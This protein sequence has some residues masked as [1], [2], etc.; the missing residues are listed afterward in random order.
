[1]TSKPYL[2]LLFVYTKMRNIAGISTAEAKKSYDMFAKCQY[3]S[4]ITM[5]KG[6]TFA[7]GTPISNSMTELYTNMRYL[8]YNLLLNLR[9]GFFDAWAANFGEIKTV[10]ELAPEGTKYQPKTRFSRFYNLSELMS[11]FREC[12][13]IQTAEMLNLPR[14]KAEYINVVLEPSK[15]QQELVKELGK[16]AE[17][18]RRNKIDSHIDN[19]LK[20]THDGR[21]LALE[22]RLICEQYEENKNSKVNACVRNAIQIWKDSALQKGTQLIFCDMATPKKSSSF[23]IYDDIKKKL[24]SAGVPE[25]EISFIHD[26]NTNL[27]KIQLFAKIRKGKVRFL[28]GSTAKMGAGTNVQNRLVAL[29]HIDVPW[30]PSDIDQREGRILRQ[31]NLFDKVMIFRYTTKGTFDSYCWQILENKQRV[32]SQIM[33][34]KS[35]VRSIEDIDEVVLNYAEIKALTTN[36][37]LIQE[38][39]NLELQVAKLKTYKNN[40]IQQKHNMEDEIT[41]YFPKKIAELQKQISAYQKDIQTYQE[42][43]EQQP[44]FSIQIAGTIY[45]DRMIAGSVILQHLYHLIKQNYNF[46]QPIAI[47][48]YL[49]FTL[50]IERN[51]SS[52]NLILQGSIS[53]TIEIGESPIGI[54]VRMNNVLSEFSKHLKFFTQNL[55]YLEE[56]LK[57]A[58][59]EVQKPFPKED[60]LKEKQAR[61]IEVNTQLNINDVK[62]STLAG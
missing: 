62:M 38:K 32:I 7:T 51:C 26:A 4:K 37:P 1:M 29:H 35:S 56:Q 30:R 48:K 43:I 28:L 39:M 14:P 46:S 19:M 55:K 20:I 18:I 8:Q 24:I 10:I 53:H 40:F 6:I 31:G 23:N 58:K 54:I 3:I 27:K 50:Q 57:N 34:H 2:S 13:D 11:L 36:N 12:A 17:H 22:Q 60:E 9:L 59:T 21:K 61:L 52:Y 49:G 25:N 44:K 42:N 33:T 41:L 47:G 5:D 16:R 15:I 45:N